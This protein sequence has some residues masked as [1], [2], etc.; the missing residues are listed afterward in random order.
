[1][2]WGKPQ[3]SKVYLIFG[4]LLH[5]EY[6]K[7]HIEAFPQICRYGKYLSFAT[8]STSVTILDAEQCAFPKHKLQHLYKIYRSDDSSTLGLST[9]LP[10]YK[11]V[12]K[13]SFE[14]KGMFFAFS[15]FNKLTVMAALLRKDQVKFSKWNSGFSN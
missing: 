8:L 4:P 12:D 14:W 9:D 13:M 5:Q 6:T 1:M 10:F 15:H 2:S 7:I 11:K 3:L